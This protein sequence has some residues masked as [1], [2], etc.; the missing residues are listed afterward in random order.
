MHRGYI[1]LWRKTVDS[2]VFKDEGLLKVWIW[3]LMK[4]T[5]K[6]ITVSF[7][8]GR[9]VQTVDLQPG[10]FV[11]GRDS[12]AVEL[13][14]KPSTVRNRIQRLCV[15][16]NVDSKADSK[17]TVI[18]ICNWDTYANTEMDGGQQSGHCEDSER[19]V[20]G[21]IQEQ[22]RTKKHNKKPSLSRKLRFTDE[23]LETASWMFDRIKDLDPTAKSEN[24]N[25]WADVI[26]LIRERDKRTDGEI[27]AL[28]GW[29]TDDSF[30]RTN[31]LCPAKL[32]KQWTQLTVKMNNGE[33]KSPHRPADVP[34]PQ[35]PH[36]D[37]EGNWVYADGQPYIHGEDYVPR[38]K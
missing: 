26:R 19:T 23:D 20:R 28:F 11:F 18:T 31:I 36:Q 6:P 4:A 5:H 35:H 15:F 30:W 38:A 32:R 37:D 14:M 7:K 29:A 16:G 25:K 22:R 33:P 1:K 27:R 24:L 21:H 3:C 34:P 8:T 9:T 2:A 17:F 13:G 12:A 10:Q